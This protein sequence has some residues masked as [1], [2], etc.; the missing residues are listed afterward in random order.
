VPG[1]EI[2]LIK[3]DPGQLEQVIVNLAVNARDSM[4]RGGR[5]AIEIELVDLDA[6]AAGRLGGLQAGPHVILVVSDSGVGMDEETRGRI[7]EP[8]FTTKDA[9]R[10]TGL[11]LATVHGIVQ[12]HQGAI[13]V[14]S[15][16]GHGATFR[17]YLPMT[18]ESLDA[19]DG[20]DLSAMP[21][22]TETVLLVEDE[23]EVRTLVRDILEQVGYVVLEAANGDEAVEIARHYPESIQLLL[24]DVIMPR[25]NG[26]EVTERVTLDRPGLK[27]MYISGYTD[28]I[29]G[30]LALQ[31][32]SRT[33]LQKPFTPDM[34]TRTVRE[35][36]DSHC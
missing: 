23:R 25:M 28:N 35:A 6:T 14:E 32:E 33:I 27:V 9:G 7:F 10:G 3:A 36:L 24:T 26:R 16:P 34:L 13:A 4:P 20:E 21:L 19:P 15:A 31:A 29:L 5:L 1:D 11:G 8:F 30:P 18:T 22:G 12:Q 2:S 17:I